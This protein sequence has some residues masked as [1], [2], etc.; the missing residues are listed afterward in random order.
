VR[1]SPHNRKVWRAYQKYKRRLKRYKVFKVK[2]PKDRSLDKAFARGE[3]V[4]IKRDWQLKKFGFQ[5]DYDI[6]EQEIDD[7]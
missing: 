2:P 3:S 5:E 1:T 4:M 7:D 6:T